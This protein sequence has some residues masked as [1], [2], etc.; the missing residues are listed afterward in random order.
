MNDQNKEKVPQQPKKFSIPLIDYYANPR[1][2]GNNVL[3]AENFRLFVE[4][5]QEKCIKR[6]L[7]KSEIEK[8]QKNYINYCKKNNYK[9]RDYLNT[10]YAY[11]LSQSEIQKGSALTK[12]EQAELMQELRKELNLKASSKDIPDVRKNSFSEARKKAYDVNK[13]YANQF[14][15]TKAKTIK[16]DEKIINIDPVK[17][18]QEANENF[19]N[20]KKTLRNVYL[21]KI[22]HSL[23][24]KPPMSAKTKKGFLKLA[25][26]ALSGSIAVAGINAFVVKPIKYQNTTFEKAQELGLDLDDLGLSTS[27]NEKQIKES[28]RLSYTSE[29]D[30]PIIELVQAGGSQ[31]LY[32]DIYNSLKEYQTTIPSVEQE[33][34]LMRELQ[35]LPE[36]VLLDK[37]ISAFNE[38][39]KDDNYFYPAIS[40]DINKIEDKDSFDSYIII[41]LYDKFSSPHDKYP[42]GDYLEAQYSKFNDFYKVDE[43]IDKLT[44]SVIG[45]NTDYKDGK[46]S[47]YERTDVVPSHL[48]KASQYLDKVMDFSTKKFKITP[49]ILSSNDKLVLEGQNLEKLKENDD[50]AR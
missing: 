35:V 13:F 50:D 33:E 22:N 2:F 27:L 17:R 29:K 16:N 43:K 25:A 18:E 34:L 41:G 32:E 19:K 31:S 46:I 20:T 49:N 42:S 7:T 3:Q 14:A 39:H 1:F 48:E 36:A 15:T 9:N 47:E 30:Q 12:D 4:I 44:E 38:A 37:T 28:L 11:I 26:F 8:M 45:I 40:A 5:G 24:Y 10:L 21:S 23:R 6:E